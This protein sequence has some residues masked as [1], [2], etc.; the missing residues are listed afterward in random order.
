V[1]NLTLHNDPNAS[2][3][4]ALT[5]TD[6][7]TL[8]ASPPWRHPP[9]GSR[10]ARVT[11]F[12]D[13]AE[14][15]RVASFDA[16]P[17][18]Q[19]VAI[20][21]IS[22]AMDDRSL[23]VGIEGPDGVM[24]LTARV[25]RRLHTPGALGR[26][27][28]DALAADALAFDRD[29]EAL[30]RVA[31]RQDAERSRLDAL[32]TQ[33][34]DAVSQIPPDAHLPEGLSSWRA[35]YDALCDRLSALTA[36][37]TQ[38]AQAIEDADR[39][40]SLARDRAAQADVLQPR[41]EACVEA[42]IDA[43]AAGG[44]L[45]LTATYRLPCALWRPE[46]LARLRLSDPNAAR[47]TVEW[48][49]WATTWQSTGEDWT[50]VTASFSTARPAQAAAPPLLQDDTL[51]T[52]PRS[53]EERSV[54]T[55]HAHE[56]SI[57][58]AAQTSPDMPGVDDGGQPL[59]LTSP[60][61]VTIPSDGLPVRVEIDQR[62]WPVTVSRRV[63]SA[64]SDAAH[65]C[66]RAIVPPSAQHPGLPLLAG[67]VHIARDQGWIGRAKLDFTA[68]GQ[69]LTLGFGTD[70]ALRVRRTTDTERPQK[71]SGQC[72]RRTIHV[73]LSNL[74]D[75]PRDLDVIERVPVSEVKEVTVEPLPCDD[76]WQADDDGFHRLS[77]TLAPN[78]HR[79]LTLR[80]EI[81]ASSNVRL[82]NF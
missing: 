52:R 70:D 80:Y 67:P 10:A 34:R 21:G 39:A 2:T 31:A 57:E 22:P 1:S 30:R 61:P 25:F 56:Q 78:T 62:V 19:W 43:G 50:D 81:R 18:T 29:A 71:F 44:P 7:A 60:H 12:E 33:W 13:R 74:S 48:T 3:G 45:T 5:A 8:A 58:R 51:Y 69:E 38:T 49:T 20:P 77:L 63:I 4:A 76:P 53:A 46:H 82:P 23:Q 65:L 73:F 54:I 41:C 28:R 26:E 47:A 27:A 37:R 16:A 64:L 17:G 55:V 35:A 9:L 75:T 15:Q 42:Q 36:A 11:F 79:Q 6:S 72:E 68:D 66:A 32:L 14:V 24:V 40:A 59:L